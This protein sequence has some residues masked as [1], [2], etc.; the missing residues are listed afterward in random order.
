MQRFTL[1][2]KVRRVLALALVVSLGFA[3]GVLANYLG[4]G[5][6]PTN[7]LKWAYYGVTSGGGSSYFTPASNG[8]SVWS[9]Q[10]DLNL[11]YSSNFDVAFITDFFSGTGWAG[12]A[13]C[14]DSQGR[15]W[16]NDP[17]VFNRTLAYCYA[18]NDR[19]D[20]DGASQSRRQNLFMHEA[21]HCFSLAHRNYT[22]SI[23]YPYVQS[24]TTLN[25]T[26]KSLINSRY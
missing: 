3:T 15:N 7:N 5:Q 23:M 6:H 18:Y 20:M 17:A 19:Y 14:Y 12:L 13:V 25:S 1:S 10:T 26:D 24:K 9:S 4:S 11:S 22:S 8:M 2:P 21:G 16:L